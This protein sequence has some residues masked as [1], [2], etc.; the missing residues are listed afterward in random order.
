MKGLLPSTRWLVAFALAS[1]LGLNLV[2]AALGLETTLV[3]TAHF[4]LGE[5]AGDSWRP[6]NL[7]H[8][9]L[10]SDAGT[11]LYDWLFFERRIKFIYP[12]TSLLLFEALDLAVPRRLWP[13]ALNA[14]SWAMVALT[15][16]LAA[17]L[18]DRGIARTA[19]G[20]P[21]DR[22]LRLAVGVALGLTFY[23]V[24]K[25][26]SL[27]QAQVVANAALAGLVS[28]WVAG[29]RATAGVLVALLC[30][31]KPQ[32]GVLALWG[33]AR[34]EWRFV[35][36]A[37]AAGAAILALSCALFGVANHWN[38][39]EVL[40]HVSRVGEAYHPNQT[41]N[42]LLN[43]LFGTMQSARWDPHVYPPPHPLVY[44]GTLLSS[45]ALLAVALWPP[46]PSRRGGVT[47][48]CLAALAATMA[49]P[50]AWEH[51]YGVLLPILALLPGVWLEQGRGLRAWLAL[52]ALY[53]VAS[54]AFLVGDSVPALPRHAIQSTLLAAAL[55][56]FAALFAL[57]RAA[58]TDGPPRAAPA[59]H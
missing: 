23:P 32:Y 2:L 55:A 47:D 3:H 13:A 22:W 48:L 25:A 31:I 45:A 27:G 26:Y 40:A 21:A 9:Y 53:A 39:L 44:A 42:G 59:A 11:P 41:V 8:A 17:R 28:A 43:R 35:G 15:A 24:V 20:A 37:A 12:P 54:N 29:R 46:A 14:L 34:R 30:A 7:A 18:L 36:A 58:S 6:M 57:R 50:I 56:L 52:A 49:S 5:Q 4:A 10:S 51:H 38:Y 1:V 16:G 33:A 19:P